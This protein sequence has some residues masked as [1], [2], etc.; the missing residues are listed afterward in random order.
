M[1]LST[2][3]TLPT[4]LLQAIPHCR[5]A[6][7]YHAPAHLPA[8]YAP[9]LQFPLDYGSPFHSLLPV[10]CRTRY[11]T[12]PRAPALQP[13][14]PCSLRT[15]LPTCRTST[16]LLHFPP[17][18]TA[19]RIPLATFHLHYAPVPWVAV[20][21]ISYM[22]VGH[23]SLTRNAAAPRPTTVVCLAYCGTVVLP[24]PLDAH[25]LLF[26]HSHTLSMRTLH[27]IASTDCRHTR[28]FT[29]HA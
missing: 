15:Y 21:H 19:Y 3:L 28:T 26:C 12:L 10:T 22:R 23:L 11:P 25:G 8:P 1:A 18:F 24:L 4:T 13:P 17:T 5:A 2:I 27:C 14:P 9:H 6:Q 7:R 20:I 16:A 29:C